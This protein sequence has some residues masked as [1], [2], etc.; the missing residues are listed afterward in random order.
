MKIIKNKEDFIE[1]IK[2]WPKKLNTPNENG[3]RVLTVVLQ[4][5][6]LDRMGYGKLTTESILE[7]IWTTSK[8]V[9]SHKLK[10]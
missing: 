7:I 5:V 9:L 2:T 10:S 1:F 8:S 4:D 3:K 6:D